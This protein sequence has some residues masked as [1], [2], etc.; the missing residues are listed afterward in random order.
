LLKDT[1]PLQRGIIRHV[2]LA[3]DLTVAMQEKDLRPTRY[4]LMLR[5]AQQFV[6]E[7]FEQNPIAQLGILGMRDG[8]AVRVSDMSGSPTDHLAALQALRAQEPKGSASLQNVLEMARGALFHAP[9]HGTR[10][11]V[12]VLGALSS[13]DPGDVH[14]TLR[15]L[16]ADRIRVG[17]VGLAAEVALCRELVVKTNSGDDCQ[18]IPSLL[19]IYVLVPTFLFPHF[20]AFFFLRKVGV[21]E[22]H[23]PELKILCAKKALNIIALAAAG[24]NCSGIR[25]R[26][27]R[28]ALPRPAHAGDDAARRALG[29]AGGA[30]AADDGLP[31]AHC[32]GAR[33]A[34]RVP[35][36]AR[37]R[38]LPV[39]ALHGQ[40][41][42]AAGRVPRVR[43]HADPVDAPSALVPAPVPA[44]QLGRGAVG[45]RA[46]LDALLRLPGA[47]PRRT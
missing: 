32:R 17:V 45:A 7:F 24:T 12:V 28:A 9:A 43:P 8:L 11:V 14:A 29:A 30:V 18:Y 26:T 19:P 13:S 36:A 21:R 35:L 20:A 27:R 37:A 4:L 44:A 41:V 39:H 3:L 15:A 16:V 31:V 33:V 40:G 10:E 46:P 34:V 38:R 2:L 1:T 6:T 23:H 42:R 47:L 5:Y 22:I 25:R